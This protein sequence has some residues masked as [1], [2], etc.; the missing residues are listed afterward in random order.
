MLLTLLCSILVQCQWPN[1]HLVDLDR[2]AQEALL[3]T[4]ETRIY[5]TYAADGVE[6][7]HTQGATRHG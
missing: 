3:Q 5:C 2:A 7:D 1:R 6:L 4:H